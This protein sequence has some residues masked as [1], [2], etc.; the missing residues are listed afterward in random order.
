MVWVV[1]QTAS[2]SFF[3]ASIKAASAAWAQAPA[4]LSAAAIAQRNHAMTFLPCSAASVP[5]PKFASL[6]G[7][8]VCELRSHLA[9]RHEKVG[10]PGK[11]LKYFLAL[12]SRCKAGPHCGISQCG[13]DRCRSIP[14]CRAQA[15]LAHGP[16]HE[17]M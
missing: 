4:R 8:H 2:P 3:A 1:Y 6:C 16:A 10:E 17:A 5:I 11:R 15:R 9:C 7:I 12:R 13:A 14:A